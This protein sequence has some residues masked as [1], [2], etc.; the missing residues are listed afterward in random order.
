MNKNLVVI[1]LVLLIILVSI[2]I[3]KRNKKSEELLKN[4]F[5]NVN[6]LRIITENREPEI[7][8]IKNFLTREECDH[9]IIKGEPLLKASTICSEN[10]DIVDESRTSWTASLGKELITQSKKDPILQNIYNRAAE[11][12][13]RPVQN[14]EPIQMVRYTSGQFYKPHHDYLDTKIDLY[15]QQVDLHGQREITFFVYL[16]DVEEGIGGETYFPKVDKKIKG[17][18]GDAVFWY[19][20]KKN[21]DLDEMTLHG[22]NPITKGTKYGLNIWVRTKEPTF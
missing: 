19:N 8:L 10:G 17:K 5:N 9:L 22:G 7:L 20:I 12:C 2:I 15:K 3:Y 11:F 14:I 21:G 16:N 18:K 1:L 13:M 6:N 4:K